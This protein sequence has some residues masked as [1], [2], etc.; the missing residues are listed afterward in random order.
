MGEVKFLKY[1]LPRPRRRME[2]NI[3]FTVEIKRREAVGRIFLAQDNGQWRPVVPA[4]INLCSV[5]AKNYL[6]I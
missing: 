1:Q 6:N 5:K 4:V 3:N 2:D